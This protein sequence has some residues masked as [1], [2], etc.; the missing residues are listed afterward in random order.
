M[1]GEVEPG[2]TE[3]RDGVTPA[4]RDAR[5]RHFKKLP[6]VDH[7]MIAKVEADLLAILQGGAPAGYEFH[8]VEVKRWQFVLRLPVAFES[9]TGF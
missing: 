3:A 7:H 5:S 1:G 4:M 9:E 2:Q 8:D 6:A